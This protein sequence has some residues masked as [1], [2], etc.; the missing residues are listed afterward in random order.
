MFIF[1]SGPNEI[2]NCETAEGMETFTTPSE[3]DTFRT[4][5]GRIVT[6]NIPGNTPEAYHTGVL[7]SMLGSLPDGDWSSA[8][9]D[10]AAVYIA[11]LIGV[12]ALSDSETRN[13]LSIVRNAFSK[14]VHLTE[15]ERN[16]IATMLLL[17]KL[18]G[19]TGD[20]NLKRQISETIAFVLAN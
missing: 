13:A 20:A 11:K 14:P 9:G 5:D 12:N 4:P 10:N 3:G 6:G 2:L 18:S 8:L 1:V 17:Q 16:P 15:T 19:E 7:Q